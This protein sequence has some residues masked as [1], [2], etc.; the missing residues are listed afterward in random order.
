MSVERCSNQEP[1]A[2]P[3]SICN[4]YHPLHN[5]NTEINIHCASVQLIDLLVHPLNELTFLKKSYP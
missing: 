1:D 2:P 4:K 3:M 5:L